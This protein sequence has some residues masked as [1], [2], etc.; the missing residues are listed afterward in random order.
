MKKLLLALACA[1]TMLASCC[2]NEKDENF[3]LPALIG[4]HMVLQQQTDARLWGWASPGSKVDV[5]A[6]WANKSV[7]T[8]ADDNGKWMLSVATPEATF[9]GQTLSISVNGQH[10]TTLSDI[11]I[12]EVWL[13]SGQSNMEMP[14]KG[15]AGC[16]VQHGT[17]DAMNVMRDAPGVRIMTVKKTQ[18]FELQEECTGKW[19]TGTFPQ[20]M[21]WSATAYYFASTLSNAL[22][23]PVGIV[24][25]SYGGAK[26]E[27][28]TSEEIVKTYDNIDLDHDA[29][30]NSPQEYLRPI[31]MYN[32]MFWPV[33]NY[34]YKGIIWYQGCSN[35]DRSTSCTEYAQRLANMVE[36][37]RNKIGLGDIP[38]HYVEIAPYDY[39]GSQD[40]CGPLLREQQYKAQALI[41]NSFMISTNDLVDP[42]ELHNIHPRQKRTV[43]ERLCYSAL[44]RVYGM[45]QICCSGPRYKDMTIE[46]NTCYISFDDLQMGICRNYMI[47]G[48]EVAGADKKFYPADNVWLRWQTNHVVVSCSKVQKPVAVRYCFHDFQPG[49]LLG[50]SELPAYPFRTDEW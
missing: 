11:L 25:S 21:E 19:E 28:W 14:L 20:T 42:F 29:I 5:K 31:M 48:F 24:N 26:V 45:N 44:N 22:N 7:S 1:M 12:G 38:F 35:A 46:G 27:S 49:T 2:N 40:E 18:S 9:E 4:D 16:N 47:E 15:F 8:K 43:G 30:M 32:A 6:S 36:L 50:G 39:D 33:K 10:Q 41:P 23:I 34:T 13:A 37:W 17:V 3:K